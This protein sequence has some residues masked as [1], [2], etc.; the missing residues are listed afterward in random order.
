[1]HHAKAPPIGRSVPVLAAPS[2]WILGLARLSNPTRESASYIQ[3]MKCGLTKTWSAES[4]E[5]TQQLLNGAVAECDAA[6]TL[7]RG[8]C[9]RPRSLQSTDPQPQPTAPTTDLCFAIAYKDIGFPGAVQDVGTRCCPSPSRNHRRR[10]QGSLGTRSETVHDATLPV[11]A[12]RSHPAFCV[13]L[14]LG[15][16]RVG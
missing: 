3:C 14:R 5:G 10:S 2:A 1:M 4:A 13:S 15:A 6:I 8:G 12:P 7:P 11:P 9:R 16:N